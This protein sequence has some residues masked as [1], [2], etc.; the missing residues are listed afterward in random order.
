MISKIVERLKSIGPGA[1]IA[2]AFIGPG[3]VVTSIK[4]GGSFGYSLLWAVAF[5]TI[6][7]LIF[8]EMAARLGVAGQVGLGEAIRKKVSHP[9][10]RFVS[11]TLVIAAIL[12]GNAAY[13]AGNIT[14]ASLGFSIAMP[15]ASE[16]NSSTKDSKTKEDESSIDASAPLKSQA[17][18]APSTAPPTSQGPHPVV[19]VVAFVAF[20][21]LASGQFKWIERFLVGL[22]AVMGLIFFVT[23]I[24]LRPS[25]SEIFRGLLTPTIPKGEGGL[26]SVLGLIGTTVVP[27]N[28][29]LH[30]SAAKKRWTDPTQI[31]EARW[32]AFLS[33][34]LGGVITGA[35]LVSAAASLPPET[36]NGQLELFVGNVESMFGRAGVWFLSI[37]FFAA[38][39]SSAITAPL[40]AAYATSEILGWNANAT[41]SGQ[42]LRSNERDVRFI[43]VWAGILLTGLALACLGLKPTYLILLAQVANGILLPVVAIFLVVVMND[44][45]IVGDYRNG[46]TSNLLGGLVVLVATF[47]GGRLLYQAVPNIVKLFSSF[48]S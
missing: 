7:C 20:G 10:L 23:A 19:F 48:W 2:A 12:I 41:S 32:D 35:I 44:R 28:L 43:F 14:G 39:L 17:S 11:V 36:T 16:K 46:L 45:N 13:E 6:A 8:Q 24:V 34:L 21:L 15:N 31:V 3:T 38:G 30:A 4:A 25:V 47:L 5:S 33:V 26:M 1:M 27:Y 9:A 29:F 42:A 37:G 22:V 18:T 40:A